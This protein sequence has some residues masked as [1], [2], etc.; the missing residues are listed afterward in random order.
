[1]ML[2]DVYDLDRKLGAGVSRYM[3]LG[4]GSSSRDL[5][6]AYKIGPGG[7]ET[8]GGQK[9]TRIVL[10]PKK[11]D[12]VM[13]LKKVD[14]WISDAT[15]IAVQQQLY[16]GDADYDLATYTN[17]KINPDIAESAVALKLPK[18]VEDTASAEVVD[19]NQDQRES[20]ALPRLA[21]WNRRP[22]HAPRAR[23]G[24]VSEKPTCEGAGPYVLSQFFGECRAAIF[25]S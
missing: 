22:D 19:E 16:T 5:G 21:A 11:P 3:L 25:L 1:M 17:M 20:P 23:V 2:V 12:E 10:T 15:G 7:P 14:L 18:G 9:S 6:E 24:F 8:V 13:H 4:F